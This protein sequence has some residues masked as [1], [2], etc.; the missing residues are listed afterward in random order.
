MAS[1]LTDYPSKNTF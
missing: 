1:N